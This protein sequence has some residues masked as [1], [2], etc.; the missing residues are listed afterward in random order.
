MVERLPL[1]RTWA[2]TPVVGFANI[3]ENEKLRTSAALAAA[4]LG[5]CESPGA[6]EFLPSVL[7]PC[8]PLI[9]GGAA[10]L[11]LSDLGGAFAGCAP[12]VLPSPAKFLLSEP[13]QLP[14]TRCVN[15]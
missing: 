5:S 7:P 10:A 12:S 9:F 8:G 15:L 11:A 4:A 6:C 2:K 1:S 13:Q 3:D 14:I